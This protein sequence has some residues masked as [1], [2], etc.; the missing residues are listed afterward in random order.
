MFNS[1]KKLLIPVLLAALGTNLHAQTVKGAVLDT[2]G[3]PLPGV[4]VLIEGTTA[5]AVTDANGT[6]QLSVQG[7]ANPVLQF[8]MI[9]M[10]TIYERVGNRQVINVV[11]GEDANYLEEV[12]VVGYQEMK[13]KDLLGAVSSVSSNKLIEQPVNSVGSALAGRMAGVSVVTT[14][15]DPDPVIKIRV[16]GTGSITQSSEPLYIIDGF[17]ASDL[18]D[19][20]ASQIQSID[21]LKDAFATAIY[22]SRG[23]NGVVIV[24]TKNASGAEKVSVN[25]NAYYGLKTMANKNAYTPMNAQEFIKAQYEMSVVRSN[26]HKP[27]AGFTNYFGTF[28]DIYLYD[29]VPTNDYMQMVF[30]NIGTNYNVD[31]SVAGKSKAGN[32][33]MTLARLGEDGIMTGSEFNRTNVGFKANMRT[34]KKT[35][36]DVNIRYSDANERG[37]AANNINDVGFSA[38]NG[39]V[40]QA[41]A[42]APIPIHVNIFDQEDEDIYFEYMVHPLRSVAD[43]DR[44]T[45]R[46]WLNLN[47]AFNWDIIKNLRF[48]SEFGYGVSQTTQDTFMGTS[49]YWSNILAT[50]KGLP[51]N[52]HYE[53][54]QQRFRNA[55]TLS[56]DFKGILSPDKHKL[57]VIIGE[58]LNYAQAKNLTVLTEG[59]PD[60]FTAEDAWNFMASG[61]PNSNSRTIGQADVMLSFFGRANYTFLD[62]YSVGATV[63]ADGS[64][65]FGAGNRWGV[66]PSAAVSWDI[67]KEPMLSGASWLDQLKL[68]Y[69]YGTAGNNNIPSGQIYAIYSASPTT[70]IA[71]LNSVWNPSSNMPNPDLTWETAV[72]QNI[73]LD[74]SFFKSRVSGSVELYDNHTNDLLIQF[75]ISG[76]GYRNQYQNRASIQNKG[77]EFTLNL[78]LVQKKDFDLSISGN[79]AYNKNKVLDIGGLDDIKATTGWA[80][81][82]ISYDYKVVKGEPL[83]NVYGYQIEGIYSVD[84]FEYVAGKWVL[85][86]GLVS[87]KDLIGDGYF[88]PGSVKLKDQNDDLVI[89]TDDMVKIGN[90]LP[91]FTGGFS[92]N[93]YFHGFDFSAN[94]NFMIGNDVYNANK[95]NFTNTR[96]WN[97]INL[98]DEVS[99]AHRWTAIDWETGEMFTDPDAYAAANKNATI[100]SPV[101]LRA[102]V[103]DYGIEDGSF[104]RLQSM[105]LG[106]TLPTRIVNK[107]HLSKLRVYVTGSNLFCLTKY[108]GYDPEVDCRRSALTPGCDF[109]AYPK[110]IGGVL[111]VN[112]G[113]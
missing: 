18:S 88:L 94:F 14:E 85:K 55:N 111:G 108:S 44:Q 4:S 53:Y 7:R 46:T 41:L 47:G 101:M 87:E 35:S 42:N 45:K 104:L 20:S 30:G 50:M 3:A 103:T 25:L 51:A 109:S 34:G 82:H 13:R 21:V 93:S 99:L 63:R 100:W 80:S 73:G 38:M 19:I 10:K 57:N 89:N 65:R 8:S 105:T 68:R 76:T 52:R 49:T 77:V 40:N 69:S 72:T 107:V 96:N 106:Y 56:Y 91:D 59:F 79:I 17:P 27:A 6:Y 90:T 31:L 9:G 61:T 60:F 43:N 95:L 97:R 58:E 113:F 24:T 54:W 98:S 2:D 32:W 48:K 86:D 66:F 71:E 67:A 75:P 81:S 36:V 26:D 16:R 15:G 70:Q 64:S 22:G 33:T 110:A 28:D 83:G 29:G 78:P 11:M 102:L 112:I 39:R 5:G 1:L 12:V 74:F 37:G 62:R 84:D 92:I 23:A